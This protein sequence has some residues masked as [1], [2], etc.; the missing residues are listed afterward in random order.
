M[1]YCN[2]PVYERLI[3]STVPPRLACIHESTLERLLSF[4]SNQLICINPRSFAKDIHSD[5]STRDSSAETKPVFVHVLPT[6]RLSSGIPK[7]KVRRDAAQP[8]HQSRST[9]QILQTRRSAFAFL[10]AAPSYAAI[11]DS[12]GQILFTLPQVQQTACG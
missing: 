2:L 7:T 9:L 4:A 5:E 3:R 12:Q 11:H 8:Y 6:N 1:Y 10:A